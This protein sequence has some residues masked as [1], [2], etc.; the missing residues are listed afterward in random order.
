MSEVQSATQCIDV[1]LMVCV[2]VCV[3]VEPRRLYKRTADW[4]F[5]SGIVVSI[6]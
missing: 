6:V 1:V 4:I 2:C 5:V 3:N